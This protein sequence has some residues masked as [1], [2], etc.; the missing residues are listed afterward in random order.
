MRAVAA[1]DGARVVVAPI[2]FPI[3]GPD[4]AAGR[5]SWPPSRRGRGCSSSATSRARPRWSCRSPSS[6]ASSTG[7]GIDTLVDGAHAPGDGAGRPRRARRGLLDR[8]RPQVAVRP[9]GRG[10]P[11]GP[12]G[13]ARADPPA[14]RVAWRERAAR[15]A[16]ALPPRVRLGRHRRPD[17]LPDAARGDRL[18]GRCAMP[19]GGGW[20]AVM[21][22]NHALALAGRDIVAA[23][24]GVEPPAPDAMLGS[25][26]AVPLAGRRRT[27]R[28]PRRSAT[29]LEA[30]DRI[31]VPIGPGRSGRRASRAA[32]PRILVRISAQRYNEPRRLRAA[33]GGARAAAACAPLRTRPGGPPKRTAGTRAQVA[34]VGAVLGVVLGVVED[35]PECHRCRRRAAGLVRAVARRSR[36]GA[37]GRGPVG[38]RG[39]PVGRCRRC[40]ARPTVPGWPPTRR[41]RRRPRGAAPRSPRSGRHGGCRW[42]RASRPARRPA[43]VGRCRLEPAGMSVPW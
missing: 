19:D 2:P 31:Q 17:R 30:E 34:G 13:P 15:R 26:A 12:R 28:R 1:R 43:A 27:R 33:G 35:P 37:R 6:S 8:Q 22:A 41:P 38:R 4:E 29:A 21:A 39:G 5:R 23:A 14:G 11:V 16:D 42:V 40:S 32:P 24:L 10:G 36:V 25:M 9:E 3:A 20:P 7:R 18:D